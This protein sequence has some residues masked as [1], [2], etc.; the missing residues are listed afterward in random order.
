MMKLTFSCGDKEKKFHCIRIVLSTLLLF[1]LFSSCAPH[2]GASVN[3]TQQMA[4][5]K[6]IERKNQ[7]IGQL[8]KEN[9]GLDSKLAEQKQLSK[10]LQTTLLMRHKETDACRE[11]NK[12]L[13]KELLQSK[14]KLATRGSRLEAA[15]LIAEATAIISA[16]DSKVLTKSQEANRNKAIH[17]LEF[18]K[19]ELAEG[20]FER[21]AFLSRKAMEQASKINQ[22][23]EG[24]SLAKKEISFSTPLYMELFI[25]GNFR[26]GPSIRANVQKVLTEGTKVKAIGFKRNWVKVQ[27]RKSEETGWI[28]LSLLY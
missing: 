26:A 23:K 4:Y 6:A 13:T 25:T 14:A 20:N 5:F 12:K 1:F 21:A 18:S 17:S 2:K 7:Q 9:A 28:H 10:K 27:L 24:I 15:T 8:E 11:A 22:G 19:T 16:V 3:G